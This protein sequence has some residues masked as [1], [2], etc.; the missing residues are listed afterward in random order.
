M[1]T[2]SSL[3][4]IE[5]GGYFSDR[6]R[7]TRS[8]LTPTRGGN[9]A[10]HAAVLGQT[11]DEQSVARRSPDPGCACYAAAAAAASECNTIIIRLMPDDHYITVCLRKRG[12]RRWRGAA[13][14]GNTRRP[15]IPSV[16]PYVRSSSTHPL[17]QQPFPVARRG[18]TRDGTRESPLGHP[19]WSH[20]ATR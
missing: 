5:G 7:G 1:A 10:G 14:L 17:N 18:D 2:S 8:C 6:F 19:S 16:C 15:L 4:I 9:L 12:G 3:N 13:S 11:A 20:S